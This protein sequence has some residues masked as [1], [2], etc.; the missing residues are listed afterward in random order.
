MEV[1]SV[2][3]QADDEQYVMLDDAVDIVKSGGIE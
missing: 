1:N 3:V 2:F